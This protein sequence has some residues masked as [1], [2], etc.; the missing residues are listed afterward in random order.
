MIESDTLF[1]LLKC[2]V[3]IAFLVVTVTLF[4]RGN[5][6]QYHPIRQGMNTAALLTPAAPRVKLRFQSARNL[7]FQWRDVDGA[8]HYQLLERSDEHADFKL[9]GA[10][11]LPGRE[12]LVWTL[13]LHSRINAQYILRA[14]NEQGFTDSSVVSVAAELEENLRYL[15]TSGIE[16]SEF[17]GFAVTLSEDGNTLVI[18]EDDFSSAY[19][20]VHGTNTSTYLGTAFIFRRASAGQWRQTAYINSLAKADIADQ[21][22]HQPPSDNTPFAPTEQKKS[23]PKTRQRHNAAPEIFFRQ[24]GRMDYK[25]S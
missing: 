7:R 11:I 5:K 9:V 20:R 21:D 4:K 24:L 22:D 15:K 25:K 18:A 16:A 12:A 6:H 23:E 3:S 14:F 17:F 8:S 10:C 1:L 2:A 13:P 19:P